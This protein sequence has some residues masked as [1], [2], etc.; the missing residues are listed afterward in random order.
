MF[1]IY[2]WKKDRDFKEQ[3]DFIQDFDKLYFKVRILLKEDNLN[4]LTQKL[5]SPHLI[6]N[7]SSLNIDDIEWKINWIFNNEES[8]LS[9]NMLNNYKEVINNIEITEGLIDLYELINFL[10]INSEIIEKN[11]IIKKY[12]KL[13]LKLF[14]NIKFFN[15]LFII[16]IIYSKISLTETSFSVDKKY[17]MIN[18]KNLLKYIKSLHLALETTLAKYM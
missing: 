16:H 9:Y 1:W 17:L 7:F 10:S 11:F 12:I 6:E 3:D 4:Y 2:S 5:Y 15:S 8:L 14:R 13:K 18:N